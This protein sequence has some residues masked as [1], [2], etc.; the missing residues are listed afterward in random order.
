MGKKKPKKHTPAATDRRPGT[1]PDGLAAGL[2]SAGQ[3]TA[4][5]GPRLPCTSGRRRPRALAA[6]PRPCPAPPCQARKVSPARP[7]ARATGATP[8]HGAYPCGGTRP[9][10]CCS[11][12]ATRLVSR[13]SP[14]ETSATAPR[15]SSRRSCTSRRRRSTGLASKGDG[16]AAGAGPGPGCSRR[17]RRSATLSTQRVSRVT[18]VESCE[19]RGE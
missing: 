6:P 19:P 11:R 18:L 13:K 7:P 14:V 5:A 2:G 12:A 9:R 1:F 3:E 10:C 17:E 4:A 15:I 8:G 16:T